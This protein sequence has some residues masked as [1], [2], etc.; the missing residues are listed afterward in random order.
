MTP[1][2][3]LFGVPWRRSRPHN[4]V[5]VDVLD[6]LLDAVIGDRLLLIAGQDR[7]MR[8]YAVAGG[9]AR[10]LGTFTDAASAWKVLDAVDTP[11]VDAGWRQSQS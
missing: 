11:S 9:R 4:D 7:P 6:D 10:S 8:L 2:R 5:P 1:S 3:S